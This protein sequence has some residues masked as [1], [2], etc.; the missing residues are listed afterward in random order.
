MLYPWLIPAWQQWQASIKTNHLAAATLLTAS[1]GLGVSQLVERVI[2]ST[3]CE[4]ASDTGCGFCHACQLLSNHTH[5]DVHR[6][7]PEKSEG[8]IVVEQVRQVNQWAYK[9]SFQSKARFIVIEPADQMNLAAANALLKTLEEPPLGCY[10]ILITAHPERLLPTIRSRCQMRLVPP[11]STVQVCD[12]L[13]EQIRE[14]VAGYV[15]RLHDNS[16][17]ATQDFLLNGG[18][19]QYQT[20]ES[21]FL[22]LLQGDLSALAPCVKALNEAPIIRLTWLWHMLADAQKRHFGYQ[23]TDLTPAS[24]SLAAMFEYDALYQASQKLV[25]L[26]TQLREVSAL[27]SELLITNWLLQMNSDKHLH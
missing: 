18:L 23:S 7:S 14:P 22:S 1:S 16:P 4:H 19:S 6:L 12:W 8:M 5:P 10:F 9:S 17:L 26:L 11:P 15:L 27:N 2:F 13:S 20:L 24:A 21:C 3:L 25:E